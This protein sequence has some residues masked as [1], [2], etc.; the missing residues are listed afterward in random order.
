MN[1]FSLG[2]ITITAFALL[3]FGCGPTRVQLRP[4]FWQEPEHKVGVAVRQMPQLH[5]HPLLEEA[6]VGMSPL[7][8]LV[9][10]EIW[11]AK[12]GALESH[13]QLIDVSRF[14]EVAD[15]Y[16]EALEARG[17]TARKLAQ[18]PKLEH[19]PPFQA[20]GSGEFAKQDLRPLA[21]KEGLD[22]LVLLSM[23]KCGA[24]LLPFWGMNAMCLAGG[25]LI[26]LRTNRVEWR[27]IMEEEQGMVTV[28]GEWNQAPDFPL[29]TADLGKAVTQAQQYLVNDFFSAAVA[30][31]CSNTPEYQA[32]SPEEK[33]RLL[34]ECAK[35]KSASV[36]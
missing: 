11:K 13:L 20:E 18:A 3:L 19:L 6:V 25:E 17:F 4:D 28:N 24:R 22:M 1:S 23:E 16:V 30:T 21:A 9:Y 35:A 12:V 32:A 26:D 15:R 5:V 33:K 27:A 14:G 29:I 7:Q 2:R 31:P 36:Q 8:E 10:V 34:R